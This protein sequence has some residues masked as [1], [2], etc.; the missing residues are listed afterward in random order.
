MCLQTM[1]VDE[2]SPA[3][4][5]CESGLEARLLARALDGVCDVANSRLNGFVERLILERLALRNAGNKAYWRSCTPVTSLS[6]GFGSS[7]Q[8]K[9]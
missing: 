2:V 1:E 6:Y 3:Q 7:S 8:L 5:H 9:P 4:N